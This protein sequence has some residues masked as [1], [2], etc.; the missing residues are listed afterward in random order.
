MKYIY[1]LIPLL[2]LAS[3]WGSDK[4]NSGSEQT[5]ESDSCVAAKVDNSTHDEDFYAQHLLVFL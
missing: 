5:A 2:L 3:C 4:S 1:T